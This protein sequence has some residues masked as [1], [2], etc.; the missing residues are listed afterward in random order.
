MGRLDDQLLAAFRA[1]DE[2]HT[3]LVARAFVLQTF[4]KIGIE[5]VE[6]DQLMSAWCN[7]SKGVSSDTDI[8]YEPFVRWLV[9]QTASQEILDAG[10]ESLVEPSAAVRLPAGGFMSWVDRCARLLETRD[11]ADFIQKKLIT[12][13]VRRHLQKLGDSGVEAADGCV[14][15]SP[16]LERVRS[17]KASKTPNSLP[18]PT[19]LQWDG[20]ALMSR[21]LKEGPKD[22]PVSFVE[23]IL[24]AVLDVLPARYVRPVVRLRVPKDGRVVVVGDTHGQ[25]QDVLLIFLLYGMPTVDDIFVFNGDVADRG[26]NACEIFLLIFSF[27]LGNP[28]TVLLL[29]GNHEDEQMNM[30]RA[31]EGGGFYDECLGKYGEDVYVKFVEVFKL[32]PLA[33]V[34]HEEVFIV[35]GGLPGGPSPSLASIDKIAHTEVCCP[36]PDADTEQDMLF[37]DLLWSDPHETPGHIPNPRGCGTLWG[38]DLTNA[39]LSE[40]NLRWIIRSHQV[41]YDYERG[42]M[43]HHLGLV[44]TV[45]SA[46]NY[47]GYEVN[48]GAV[49]LLTLGS[50]G[51]VEQALRE[52]NVPSLDDLAEVA[53]IQDVQERGTEKPR[54]WFILGRW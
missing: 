29:R 6:V 44:F 39:F 46:S 8:E 1:G 41:P 7:S 16:A 5:T 21:L 10:D 35:H 51:R 25:L 33:S 12:A 38:P 43:E 23:Q 28:D 37:V 2:E 31:E 19:S 42:W 47:C 17:K 13:Q 22:I 32:L 45:F 18:S 30:M 14:T 20:P 50:D 27:F 4:G 52:H 49:A 34:V 40:N 15:G 9:G 24:D 48:W 36:S 54:A 26:P 11:E 3:G 53:E